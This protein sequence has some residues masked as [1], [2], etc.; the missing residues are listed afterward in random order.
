MTNPGTKL[1]KIKT[2]IKTSVKHF[3]EMIYKDSN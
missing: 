2:N 1:L 3:Y